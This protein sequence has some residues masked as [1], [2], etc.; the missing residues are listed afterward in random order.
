MNDMQIPRNIFLDRDGTII[1]DK[2]Y[3]SDPNEVELLPDVGS[4]LSMFIE[5]GC[6]LFL[7][8]NQSGIGRGFFTDDSVLACH[9]KLVEKLFKYHVQF[10]DFLWCPH[11]PDDNCT[12]RKPNIGMWNILSERYGLLASESIM[13]G[14]KESDILFGVQAN[15]M[16]SFLVKTGN[17]A[18]EGSR[19]GY[20]FPEDDMLIQEN[21]HSATTKIMTAQSIKQ[22]ALW[23]FTQ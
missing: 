5:K 3:L 11:I 10:I 20:T 7:I 16:A 9:N 21:I 22:I 8:S 19:L 12:C 15:F 18:K 13:I 1:E 6:H 14:D 4:A 17:G 2:N 23:F